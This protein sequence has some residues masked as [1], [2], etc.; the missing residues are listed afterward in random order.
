MKL[1]SSGISK[2]SSLQLKQ[3]FTI[4]ELLLVITII[5]ILV[6]ILLPTLNKARENVYTTACS[7]NLK[8]VGSVLM[9]YVGDYNDF[10]P[11]PRRSYAYFVYSYINATPANNLAAANITGYPTY[12]KHNS[13]FV[14]PLSAKNAGRSFAWKAGSQVGEYF[15]PTY[16]AT[17]DYSNSEYAWSQEDSPT[18]T[19]AY[20]FIKLTKIKGKFLMSEIN[21]RESSDSPSNIIEK[22]AKALVNSPSMPYLYPVFTPYTHHRVLN[23]VHDFFSSGMYLRVDGAVQKVRYAGNVMGK[24]GS[25]C[26]WTLK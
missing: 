4:V 17:G 3:C 26:T 5:A 14:C 9:F 20:N 7:S 16:L 2:H 13:V 11:P 10:L 23:R 6:S 25:L 21:Y 22:N 12:F 8:N 18:N 24:D 1:L 15:S 19:V